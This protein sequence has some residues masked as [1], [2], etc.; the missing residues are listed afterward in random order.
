MLHCLFSDYKGRYAYTLSFYPV[1]VLVTINRSTYD[2]NKTGMVFF[3][4]LNTVEL[5]CVGVFYRGV[6]KR[7]HVST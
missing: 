5:K 4:R 6:E 2:T 1:P 3:L 7:P